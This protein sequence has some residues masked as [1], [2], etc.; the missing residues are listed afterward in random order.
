[1]KRFERLQ[2][3]QQH[4][5]EN[6]SNLDSSINLSSVKDTFRLGKFQKDSNRPRPILV[7]FLRS[8]DVQS[9][10]SKKSSLQAPISIKPDMT[11]EER[12]NEKILLNQC[13]LL[14]QRGIDRKQIKIRGINIFL[15]NKLYGKITQGQFCPSENISVSDNSNPTAASATVP[16]TPSQ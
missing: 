8:C 11:S 9:I 15:N 10:L 13:W 14:L 16:P 6:L 5:L 4:V 12:D 7:K 3:D 2:Q 1:M